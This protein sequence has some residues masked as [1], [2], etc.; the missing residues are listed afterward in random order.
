ML[1][2][3]APRTV[4]H[5]ALQSIDPTGTLSRGVL[6]LPAF[7]LYHFPCFTGPGRNHRLTTSVHW[8]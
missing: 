2:W 6:P 5:T 1:T 3:N 7:F 8:G 4:A